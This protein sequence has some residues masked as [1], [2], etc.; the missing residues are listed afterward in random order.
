MEF[1]ARMPSDNAEPGSSASTRRIAVV[2]TSRADYGHLVWP[3]RALREAPGIDLRILAMAAHL[4]PTF[5]NTVE[6]I[7]ADGFDVEAE[8]ECLLD[9]DSDVGMAKTIGLATLSLADALG[10]LRPDL[11]LLIAD[12]YEMLA[13]ASAALALRIPV[14][15]I[16]G[17][18]ISEGAV[19]DAVRNALTKMAHL[20]FA[21]T[22][23]AAR[24]I[25]AMGE[26]A[27][28]VHFS[29][30]PSLDHLVKSELPDRTALESRLGIDLVEPPIVVSCHPVTLQAD[31]SADALAVCEALVDA[32][33]P[34]VFCF[35]N[36][37]TGHARIIERAREL[38]AGHPN[39]RLFTHLDHLDYWGLLRNAAMLVGNSSSG[40]MET[41]SLG[42]P[43]VDVGRRQHRR[44][45]AANIVGVPADAGAIRR[46]IERAGDPAFRASLD[47][48]DNPYG[49]GRAAERIAE[50]L[51][52]VP[53]GER[54]LVKRAPDLADGDPP[55]FEA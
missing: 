25:R 46:A 10:R 21:P 12:R 16:E 36:A 9:S 39:R 41:P 51:I 6:R 50:V 4:A 40:I 53:L 26:E 24:R 35:P 38:C 48:L 27:W 13:P 37:D 54:L 47:G 31:P 55:R 33:R 5:G 14:A 11:L 32:D 28:R 18:E 45:R 17:G 34:L 3:L 43:C 44:E 29:G 1:L 2:T 20:H 23:N 22:R 49:D 19:D 42:L 52:N 15:H 30:A 7:R 8:L